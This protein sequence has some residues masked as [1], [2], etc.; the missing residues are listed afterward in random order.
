MTRVNALLLI[1]VVACAIGVITSQHKARK[2]FIDLEAEQ[3][4]AARLAEEWSQ[5][6]LEQG[7]WAAHK[8]VEAVASRSLG[9]RQPDASSTVILTIEAPAASGAARP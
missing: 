5:L 9:M 2:L 8:R 6:Q 4:T 3:A 7:T 1:A